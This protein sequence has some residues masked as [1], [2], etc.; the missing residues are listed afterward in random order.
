MMPEIVAQPLHAGAGGEHDGLDPP[1]DHPRP[2]PADDRDGPGGTA[3]RTGWA[4]GAEALVEHP[5]GA[6]GGLGLSWS[7]AALADERGLLVAG[8]TRDGRPAGEHA[9][10]P[11]RAGGVDDGG[12]DRVGDA[13]CGKQLGAPSG[14]VPAEEPGHPGVGGIGDVQIA[15]GEGP[16]HP[17]VDGAE[18]QLAACRAG[19]VGVGLVEDGR[20]LGG[21]R[22]GRHPEALGL[23]LDAGAHRAQVLP[24]EPGSDRDAGGPVP[25]DGR[26]ALVGDAHGV[27]RP[28]GGQTAGGD[29]FHRCGDGGCVEL[30]Q[31]G[32]RRLRQHRDVVDVLDG[33]VRTDHRA[34]HSRGTHVDDQDAHG[35]GAAAERAVEAELARVEDAVGV[36]RAA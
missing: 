8:D 4:V 27:D 33:R 36:E 30:D 9:G 34:P 23:E 31:T 13:Q 12:Q 16:G 26:R 28:A 6:E 20:N 1:G 11:H 19:T 29:L 32:E 24:P 17:G 5:A 7:G 18:G 14:S 2:A 35:Q 15:A 10:G 3:D 21:R 25:D 22:I